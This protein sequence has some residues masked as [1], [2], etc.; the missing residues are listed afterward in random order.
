M[1]V[2]LKCHHKIVKFQHVQPQVKSDMNPRDAPRL[3]GNNNEPV[4][5]E[6]HDVGQQ[7]DILMQSP[8]HAENGGGNDV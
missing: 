1:I 7:N 8:I 3:A 2:P 6:P 5:I 4:F